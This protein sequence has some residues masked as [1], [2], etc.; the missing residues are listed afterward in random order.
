MKQGKGQQSFAERT[1]W[2]QQTPSSNS[3]LIWYSD[4]GAAKHVLSYTGLNLCVYACVL[5]CVQLFEIPWTVACQAP[6]SMEFSRQE[7][8]SGLPF[9]S[10][11][12]HPTQGSNL[13]LLC[14]L[15]WQA[16]TL[17][18]GYC[19]TREAPGVDLSFCQT[20][21]GNNY[22]ALP[23]SIQA[24]FQPLI[25]SLN[26]TCIGSQKTLYHNAPTIHVQCIFL[27]PTSK[28]CFTFF[29]NKFGS[30]LAQYFH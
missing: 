24:I 22:A 27:P 25:R 4:P 21:P 26:C 15:H 2:S 28:L 12:D 20:Q 17:P 10:S 1:H 19:A 6:L 13:L 18:P 14:P 29:S 3:I 5:S 9:S 16:D 8:W 11:G 30:H 7:Y 23:S